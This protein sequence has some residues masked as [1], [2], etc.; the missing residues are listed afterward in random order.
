MKA[1]ESRLA[2]LEQIKRPH[3]GVSNYRRPEGARE[4]VNIGLKTQRTKS[5]QYQKPA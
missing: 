3:A 1:I 2:K 5:A 4:R